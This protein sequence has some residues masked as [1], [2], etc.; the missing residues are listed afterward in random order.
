MALPTPWGD[1]MNIFKGK[2]LTFCYKKS[3]S[4]QKTE[5]NSENTRDLLRHIRNFC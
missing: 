4:I 1:E 5:L 2:K 3:Y